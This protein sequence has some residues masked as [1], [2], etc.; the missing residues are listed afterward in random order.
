MVISL[1]VLTFGFESLR[2]NFLEVRG[3]ATAGVYEL[4]DTLPGI[5]CFEF[6]VY[7]LAVEFCVDSGSADVGVSHLLS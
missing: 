3:F 6:L 5:S 2:L 4:Q 1:L 7:L